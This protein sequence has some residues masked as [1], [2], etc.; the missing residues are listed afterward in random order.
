MA[1]EE[2]SGNDTLCN[3]LGS[4]TTVAV[5]RQLWA[6]LFRSTVDFMLDLA[7]RIFAVCF[8]APPAVGVLSHPHERQRHELFGHHRSKPFPL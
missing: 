4:V 6:L 1:K 7:S 3:P 2:K 5:C 8:V